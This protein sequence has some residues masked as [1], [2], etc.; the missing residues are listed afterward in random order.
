MRML[1][2]LLIFLGTFSFADS[3]SSQTLYVLQGSEIVTADTFL[4]TPIPIVTGIGFGPMIAVDDVAGFVFWLDVLSVRRASLD[5]TGATTLVSS[6]G[7]SPQWM[8]VNPLTQ[9]VWWADPGVLQVRNVGYSG[10]SPQADGGFPFTNGLALDP[11]NNKGYLCLG[12]PGVIASYDAQFGNEQLVVGGLNAPRAVAVDPATEILYWV[13]GA[14]TLQS[15]PAATGVV[16]THASVAS[17]GNSVMRIVVDSAAGQLY[18]ATASAITRYELNGTLPQVVFNGAGI[19]D[20]AY[21]PA[22]GP[23]PEPEFDRGDCNNDGS[24]NIADMIFLLGGLFSGGDPGT[25]DD[26]CDTNDDGQRNIADAIAG[27]D[28][29]FGGGGLGLPSPFGVCGLDPTDSDPFDCFEN[30][31]CP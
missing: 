28:A 11:A 16:T 29:L 1:A 15:A 18:V 12:A 8:T 23:G 21:V 26:A 5:G 17:S 30:A 2:G 13:N 6:P 27:L 19:A 7:T 14:G 9:R 3:A 22:S 31:G 4:S 25:C 24:F 20:F 10:A